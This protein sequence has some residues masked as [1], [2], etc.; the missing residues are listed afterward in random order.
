MGGRVKYSLRF[1]IFSVLAALAAMAQP[2][3]N[4][5]L[6][7]ASYALPP[8]PNSGI[9][10]GSLMVIFGTNVANANATA[11]A[12]PI[13]LTMGGSSVRVTVGGTTVDCLMIYTTQNQIG[14][15]L[16]SNTPTG[17]GSVVVTVNGVASAPRPITVVRSS[18][19]IFTA[20]Q[21]GSGP[22]AIQIAR[23]SGTTVVTATNP[24]R[25]GDTMI[26]WGTGIGPVSGDERGGALPGDQ[27]SLAAEVWVGGRQAQL[28]YRGRSGCCVGIDQ[29]AFV[30]PVGVEGCNVPVYVKTGAVVSNFSSIAVAPA[31]QNTCSD[32]GGFSPQDLATA[33]AN[34]GLRIGTISLT[35]TQTK[36]SQSGFSIDQRADIGSA[37]FLRFTT[38]QLAV[39][40]TAG[41]SY[42]VSIGS[43]VVNTFR[44][45]ENATFVEPVAPT[46]LDAGAQIGLTR[47]GTTRNLTKQAQGGS[48]FADLGSSTVI[49]GVP[50]IPGLPGAGVTPFLEQG[51]YQIANGSGGAGGN[52]VG[53]FNFS[54]TTPALLNWI[55]QDAINNIP[56]SS[57]LGVTWSGGDPAGFVTVSGISVTTEVGSL[58]Y[59]MERASAGRLTVPSAV[60]SLMLPNVGANSLGLLTVSGVSA[61]QRFTAPGLDYGIA[62]SSSA[63]SKSVNY[64]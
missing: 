15:V 60:L 38:D 57:D 61:S 23:A 41:G 43:C 13:P 55:N 31:G 29:I 25:A 50:N 53:G 7:N 37:S 47:D 63:N 24:A 45:G 9:A 18:F 32:P 36:I 58:F 8:L 10:Q 51:R 16:P 33:S 2:A 34:G 5:V 62:V 46:V 20:N 44:G 19:G 11:T 48:Y 42:G 6:N 12:F 30:V 28:S 26:I 49:P 35:R 39:S 64:Q 59:C 21:A 27:P 22:G 56:R 3:V 4:A 54:F 14:V 17:T 1:L 52:A 40:Q